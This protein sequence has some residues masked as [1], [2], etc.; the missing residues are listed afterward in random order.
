MITADWLG[1]NE[2]VA[3][4]YFVMRIRAVVRKMMGR[5]G[6]QIFFVKEGLSDKKVKPVILGISREAI[7]R[8]DIE[9][10]EVISQHSL[11][12]VTR[13]SANQNNLIIDYS[14]A[15]ASFYQCRTN[16]AQY[17]TEIFNGMIKAILSRDY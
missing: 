6:L 10:L 15:D 12:E 5:Y 17:I 13:I 2:T 8:M 11:S 14:T 9:T 3:K 16:Q 1:A 4:L 7:L